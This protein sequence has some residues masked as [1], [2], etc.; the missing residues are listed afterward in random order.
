MR[1]RQKERKEAE[2]KMVFLQDCV[3]RLVVG[4]ERE[5][6]KALGLILD[7]PEYIN[8]RNTEGP[9][10]TVL[11]FKE[12]E[13]RKGLAEVSRLGSKARAYLCMHCRTCNEDREKLNGPHSF[14]KGCMQAIDRAFGRVKELS[15][16]LVD[17]V[18]RT[19]E[20]SKKPCMKQLAVLLEKEA[21][22][23]NEA[24]KSLVSV[25]IRFLEGADQLK[26]GTLE[27]EKILKMV[28]G[29]P[30]LLKF[31]VKANNDDW[32][33]IHQFNLLISGNIEVKVVFAESSCEV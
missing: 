31:D 18:R 28:L 11:A 5:S 15:T 8:E 26:E 20:V 33:Q 7:Q 25:L 29:D 27:L 12:A 6:V 21:D 30:A 22:I 24:E 16:V 32:D 9:S 14:C 2:K 19:I 10:A 13:L 4:H 17:K 1:R 3:E 23:S